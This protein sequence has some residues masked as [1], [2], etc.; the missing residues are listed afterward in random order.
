MQQ[1]AL[2]PLH[3][4][5]GHLLNKLSVCLSNKSFC[6]FFFNTF[7]SDFLSLQ[8]T[9]VTPSP[10][11]LS[12]WLCVL[13]TA[14]ICHS[15]SISFSPLAWIHQFK[16]CLTISPCSFSLNAYIPQASAL[17]S[18][19]SSPLPSCS[20]RPAHKYLSLFPFSSPFSSLPLSLRMA[21]QGHR[22]GTLSSAGLSRDFLALFLLSSLHHL[23][24]SSLPDVLPC[25][26]DGTAQFYISDGHKPL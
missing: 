8:T 15:A 4:I 22:K 10:L 5:V 11:P 1:H 23:L 16:A 13:L 12:L 9:P 20:P 7:H 21:F 24:L 6:C 3:C 19:F 18:F 17:L 26:L 14:P 2:A 25:H